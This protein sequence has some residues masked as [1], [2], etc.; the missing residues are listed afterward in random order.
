MSTWIE[1]SSVKFKLRY[2]FPVDKRKDTFIK[3]KEVRSIMANLEI[4]S[5]QKL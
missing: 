5:N 4:E 3:L 1:F 2:F